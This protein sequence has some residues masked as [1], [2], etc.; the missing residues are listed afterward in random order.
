MLC[1]W[2][3]RFQWAGVDDV[4]WYVQSNLYILKPTEFLAYAV[5]KPPNLDHVTSTRGVGR[6]LGLMVRNAGRSVHVRHGAWMRG[7]PAQRTSSAPVARA[8]EHA[9]ANFT[10]SLYLI[11][12][13]QG[14]SPID[15]Q[16]LMI[17][18]TVRQPRHCLTGSV[19][20]SR[21]PVVASASATTLVA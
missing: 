7:M 19:L 3:E 9:T 5:T 1:S 16:S 15:S 8:I 21:Y 14:S 13:V 20:C 6:N 17:A 11:A 10:S 2:L 4:N 18:F 12:R